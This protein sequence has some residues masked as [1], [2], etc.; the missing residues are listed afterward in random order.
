MRRL[1]WIEGAFMGPVTSGWCC[2]TG[3]MLRK[4]W[5]WTKMNCFFKSIHCNK[6]EE[7]T[8]CVILDK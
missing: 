3:E 6:S 5:I 4:W 7:N 2:G 1:F 8:K